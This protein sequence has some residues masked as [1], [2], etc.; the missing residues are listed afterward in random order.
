MEVLIS[1][2]IIFASTDIDDLFILTLF[3]GNKRFKE[4]EI[5]VGQFLGIGALILLSLLA[6]LVGL[7][8]PLAYVSLLGLFP[9]YLG[10]NGLWQILRDKEIAE[11][12]FNEGIEENRQSKVLTVAGIT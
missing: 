5:I 1:S 4:R 7:I 6:S 3:F 11:A 2:V 12:K 10:A 8:I 9:I